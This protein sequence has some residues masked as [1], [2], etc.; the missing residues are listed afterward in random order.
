MDAGATKE[1]AL[2]QV[3][4]RTKHKKRTRIFAW[5]PGAGDNH[6]FGKYDLRRKGKSCI[7]LMEGN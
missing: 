6:D 2:G 4:K 3:G 7:S 5:G 1:C